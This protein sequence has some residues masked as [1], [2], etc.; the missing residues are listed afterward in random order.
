MED[1]SVE[2]QA[3]RREISFT[4]ASD[5]FGSLIRLSAL[6]TSLEENTGLE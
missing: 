1:D 6:F 5:V 3:G 4:C 2:M